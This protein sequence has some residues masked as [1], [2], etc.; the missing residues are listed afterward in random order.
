MP[1]SLT[2]AWLP[3]TGRGTDRLLQCL[4]PV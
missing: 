3:C 4:P 1:A 2:C